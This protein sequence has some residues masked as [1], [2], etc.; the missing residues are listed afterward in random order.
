MF[1]FPSSHSLYEKV[2]FIVHMHGG[3]MVALRELAH[4]SLVDPTSSRIPPGSVSIGFLKACVELGFYC[5]PED[6]MLERVRPLPRPLS[7]SPAEDG[8]RAT[9]ADI[10]DNYIGEDFPER[11]RP[12]EEPLGSGVLFV[13]AEVVARERSRSPRAALLSLDGASPAES[14]VETARPKRGRPPVGER[15]RWTE[16]Q[17][18]ALE[19][20]AQVYENSWEEIRRRIPLLSGFTGVQLKD[21]Y[22]ATFGSRAKPAQS[23]NSR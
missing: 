8:E 4:L 9:T 10:V 17:T 19:S 11:S 6:F 14:T 22:R 21:K 13:P 5:D 1:Y 12:S 15:A 16:E 18:A 20:A 3:E 2:R 7:S 23:S